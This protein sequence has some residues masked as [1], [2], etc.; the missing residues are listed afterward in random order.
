MKYAYRFSLWPDETWGFNS[1][2]FDVFLLFNTRVELTFTEAEFEAFR[3]QLSHDGFTMRG[4]VRV[5]Y[6]E[7]EV[8]L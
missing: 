7:P 6:Q 4:I 1:A 5:Q 8:V 2:L 3:S